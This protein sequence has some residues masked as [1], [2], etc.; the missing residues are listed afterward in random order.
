M[1]KDEATLKKVWDGIMRSIIAYNEGY[2][3]PPEEQIQQCINKS[4]VAL[5]KQLIAEY[6]LEFS[7]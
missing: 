7:L 2:N 3:R 1:M 5:A 4:D 6:N